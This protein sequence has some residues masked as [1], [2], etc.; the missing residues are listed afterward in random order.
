MPRSRR[1]LQ[2]A[3]IVA[4]SMALRGRADAG[5]LRGRILIGERPAVGVTVSAIPYEPPDVEARRM[6]AKGDAPRPVASAITRGDGTFAVAVPATATAAVRLRVEGGGVVPSWVGGTYDAAESDDLGEHAVAR[7]ETLAGKI[8]S[9]SGAPIAGASVTVWPLAG[10]ARGDGEVAPAAR[11]VIT[12][13][14]ACSVRPSGRGRQPAHDRGALVR[15]RGR[16]NAR[17][18]MPRPITLGLGALVSGIVLRSDR[19]TPAAG[20]LVRLE[21]GGLE[22]PW[23]EAGADGRFQLTDLPARA[24]TVVAEGGD[25]GLGEAATGPLPAPAGHVLTL[26]LAAPPTLEGVVLDTGTRAPVPR[27]RVTVEDETR[28]RTART[29]PDGRYRIRGLLPQRP[30][31]LR[32]DEPRYT[33]YVRAFRHRGDPARRR[34]PD[35][36]RDAGRTRCRRRGQDGGG[37]AGPPSSFGAG[38][39]GRAVGRVAVGRSPGL[40][41][42]RGRNVQGHAPGRGR[43]DVSTPPDFSRR[44]REACPSR[45]DRRRRSTSCCGAA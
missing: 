24:G 14:T 11:T 20:A 30:Y 38:R 5:E 28:T 34:A 32:A 23:V 10:T 9:A 35:A 18:A 17:G 45:P 40:P 42:G 3:V 7:A 39:D 25:A 2:C 33:P 26:V 43:G 29:G 22:T 1:A 31:R 16:P 44:R 4:A 37:R 19:R 6:A 21:T 13:A 15:R 41:H 8:V 27:V 36:G 12:G